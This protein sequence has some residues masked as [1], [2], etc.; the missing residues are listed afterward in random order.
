MPT[1][2]LYALIVAVVSYLLGCFNGS[3]IVSKYI[4]KN[5]I[6]GH[7]SGNAGLT[8]FYRTFGGGLTALVLLGD[9]LK[10]VLAFFFG[11]WLLGSVDFAVGGE[12]LACFFV[13][14]GHTF[15]VFFGFRGGKGV[16]SGGTLVA[17]IDLRIFAV[18]IL[19]FLVMVVLTRYISLGSVMA[20]VFFPFATWFF[21]QN[22]FYTFMAVL[23]S[24]MLVFM[25]R[26]N[27]SRIV[28]GTENRFSL[29]RKKSP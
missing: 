8:N 23:C 2:Y 24:A 20:A 6:R 11:R 3:I 12:F 9:I 14:L 13:M 27:L 22:P 21:W 10:A 28:N 19:V 25:H 16:L 1:L 15:P 17:L 7:G 26:G 5:D 18:V 4:L 29:R